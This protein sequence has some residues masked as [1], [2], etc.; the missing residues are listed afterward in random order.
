M[1]SY[2]LCVLFSGT[3]TTEEA[4]AQAKQVEELLQAA[5]AEVKHFY[6]LGRRKLAYKLK[7]ETNGEYRVWL[8]NAEPENMPALSE[9]LRHANFLVRH[10][11]LKLEDVTI[12][13]RIAH[14]EQNKTHKALASE[15][16]ETLEEEDK[17]PEAPVHE[18]S[19][20]SAENTEE[21]AEDKKDDKKVGIEK[22]DE[23]LDELLESDKM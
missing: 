19:E 8:F 1:Q 15:Q 22:L 16:S 4:D 23:K 13:Q 7:G 12:E 9:K 14:I 17:K 20:E 6:S 5:G 10:L 11:L 3:Q 21:T 18:S 2:D